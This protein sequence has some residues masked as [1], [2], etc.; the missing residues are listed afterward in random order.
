MVPRSGIQNLHDFQMLHGLP[1]LPVRL[2]HVKLARKVDLVGGPQVHGFVHP[3]C[4]GL[5]TRSRRD[6][7][8]ELCDGGL[9]FSFLHGGVGV[10]EAFFFFNW[11]LELRGAG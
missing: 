1:E 5:Q 2:F 10:Q 7:G 11:R 9:P 6:F 4:L 8:D 3:L